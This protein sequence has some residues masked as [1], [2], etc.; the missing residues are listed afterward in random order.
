MHKIDVQKLVG[1][2]ELNS[3][4]Y[5]LMGCI[6]LILVLD[7]Y[8]IAITGAALPA[9]MAD[10]K[11]DTTMGGL[12]VS[13]S[14]VGMAFGTIGFGMLADKIGRRW[15]LVIA[16]ALFSI[17]TAMTA[18]AEGPIV[19]ATLR[20]I[21][22]LGMGGVVPIL[23]ALGAEYSPIKIR[24]RFIAFVTACGYAVGGILAALAGKGLIDSYGWQG[25]FVAAGAPV[26]LIPFI[27]KYIP[28]SLPLL[29]K[30][31]SDA[32]LRA[33]V[34]K[35]SPSYPL[36]PQE[37]FLVPH[38]DKV[39][40]TPISKVFQDGRAFSTAM[41]WTANFTGLFM[42]YALTT[43]LT[44]LMAM[45]GYSLGSALTYL[46]VFNIG[47]AVGALGG[48]WL[49][50][51]LHAKWVLFSFYAMSAVS[52]LAMGVIMDYG[53]AQV[54]LFLIVGAVGAFTVGTQILTNAYVG[55]FY[56]T[57]IRNTACGLSYGIGRIGGILAPVIVG[58]IVGL[59]LAPQQ[60]L[61]AIGVVGV[62]G[63]IAIALINHSASASA[64]HIDAV[65]GGEAEARAVAAQPA[66][67]ARAPADGMG[68]A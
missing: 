10:L 6:I 35:F 65:N 56:P 42:V 45:F 58:W 17:F 37:E 12:M 19:F 31:N 15:T 51:K 41:I 1:G 66:A 61:V 30:K 59:N 8:D 38:E 3:F 28:E 13:V 24:A 2:A 23:T 40:A 57:A 7:G 64:H 26:V 4:H 47:V 50:D 9:I 33:I 55:M 5:T 39:K 52:L 32:E 20:F 63:A 27:L 44:K 16:V 43:W 14:L 54:L 18:L 49:C 36:Q 25:V 34:R 60:N 22:G 62:I 29:V 53:A 67:R 11:I 21:A 46:I 68:R 48:A